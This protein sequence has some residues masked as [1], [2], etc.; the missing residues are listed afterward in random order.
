MVAMLNEKSRRGRGHVL[1]WVLAWAS[2]AVAFTGGTTKARN[3]PPTASL[4]E[5]EAAAFSGAVR[6]S[7]APTVPDNL[8]KREKIEFM[9]WRAWHSMGNPRPRSKEVRECIA[10]FRGS[11]RQLGH[12][13][14]L[15]D[16]AGGHGGIAC[17]F[18]AHKRAD[19]A[20]VVD[21]YQP[22][23]FENLRLAWADGSDASV[24]YHI[25]DVS[26][27]D[28]LSSLLDKEAG[29]LQ[30]SEIGVVSCH[31][32]S[33]LSDELIRACTR[34]QVDFALMPCCHGE[35]SRKGKM[36]LN[37]AKMLGIPHDMLID[38]SRLGI[39]EET[40]GYKA[41]MRCIDSSITPQN[42]ILLGLRESEADA[43]KRE[44]ARS[45]SLYRLA[46]KYRHIGIP[47]GKG[48]GRV[49]VVASPGCAVAESETNTV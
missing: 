5:C 10:F 15:V 39:I 30:P 14:L 20:I 22:T 28:W 23:S 37:T 26:S 36:M 9:L 11:Q 48:T 33:L 7:A 2:A 6:V 21:L 27:P 46:R 4:R 12:K 40:S 18:L 47:L 31:A 29:D 49:T 38:I 3:V 32:C 25:A 24:K 8:T 41:S 45:A 43:E 42:R 13:K 17:V 44:L 34:S 16:A 35:D 1:L 19:R